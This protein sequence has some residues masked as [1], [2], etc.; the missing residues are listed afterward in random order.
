MRHIIA[1]AF[2]FALTACSGGEE[3]EPTPEPEAA[4]EPAPEPEPEPEP[5]GKTVDVAKLNA[6]REAQAGKTVTVSGFYMSTTTQ[7]DPVEQLNVSVHATEDM[8][9]ESI[10]CVA[11]PE[12]EAELTA[13]TQKAPILVTGTVSAD[14]FMGSAKLDDCTLASAEGGDDAH[15]GDKGGKKGKGGKGKGGKSKH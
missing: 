6:N 14:D 9:S 3:A 10:L 5:A 2:T 1:I 15:G 11:S 8:S 4:P 12:H 13:L 7:G